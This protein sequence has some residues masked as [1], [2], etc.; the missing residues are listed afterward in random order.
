[1]L[2]AQSAIAELAHR[3]QGTGG[4]ILLDRSGTPGFAHN[5][6]RMAQAHI[7]P[8]GSFLASV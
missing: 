3:T 6:P 7:A 4:I 2:A 8:D 5:T 1:M